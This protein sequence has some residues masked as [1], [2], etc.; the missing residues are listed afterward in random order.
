MPLETPNT[1]PEIA[2]ASPKPSGFAPLRIPL[3]RD[4]WI[5]STVSSVGTWMQDTAGTWLMTVL[6]SSPL[7]IALMQTAASLPV[8]MLG[9]LSGAMADIFDRRKLLIFWQTWMLTSVGILALLTFVGWVSPWT[10]LAFTFLLNV[11]SAMNNPAWQAIVPELVPRAMIPETVSLNAASNN[12]ARAVGPALGGLMVAAFKTAHTG[13]GSVFALNA[14]SFAGVIWVLVNWKRVP[15]FKSALPAERIEGSIRSGLRYV[16]YAPDLR[17]S[18]VRAFTFP[19]FISAIWSLLAV[20][21]KRDLKQGPL[22]YG[23][24]N[25]SMGLGAVMA[26][27]VLYRVRQRFSADQILTATTLYNVAVLLILA[28]VR[29]PAVIIPALVLSGAAWTST[30]STINVS[31]QLA[32]PAWVQARALG[33]YMMTFQGGMALGSILWGAIAQRTSTPIALMCAAGGLLVTFPWVRRYR[34]LYGPLPDHTPHRFKN[35]VPQL[36]LDAEPTDGPVRISVEYR[37]PKEN[38][39]EFTRA[40]HQLRGVRLRDGAVRWGIYRD[41]RDPE[42]LDETFIMESWIDYL[43]SRERVTAADEAIRARVRALHRHDEPPKTS[44]QIYAREVAN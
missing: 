12:L 15:L 26:A 38:Y 23:I 42:H 31:V 19:F 29:S 37:I 24:L 39:A 30:M 43:R 1:G 27:T 32:V 17:A 7:L 8:L 28:F 16:R 36:A 21:A 13:A 14:I 4:R 22:G 6:T 18:L 2:I 33:T 25:G 3:F 11:G 10:L 41:A 44:Y 20:V 34:I 5:A 40:I 35:P 9:L